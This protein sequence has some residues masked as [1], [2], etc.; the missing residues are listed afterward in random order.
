[1]FQRERLHGT[2]AAAERARATTGSEMRLRRTAI[3]KVIAG[4]VGAQIALPAAAL[5]IG[6]PSHVSRL[7]EPLHVEI[8]I[9]AEADDVDLR[10]RLMVD[11]QIGRPGAEA[12]EIAQEVA[13][14]ANGQ[15]VLRITSRAVVNEPI[16]TLH[17]DLSDRGV[18][19]RRDLTLLF[20]PPIVDVPSA[21]IVARAAAL[22]DAPTA[23]AAGAERN[24]EASVE[25]EA[26]DQPVTV[27]ALAVRRSR[28]AVARAPVSTPRP[29]SAARAVQPV[30]SP[31]PTQATAA[32]TSVPTMPSVSAPS[33]RSG[34]RHTL[35]VRHG[36]T[37]EQIAARVR[38]SAQTPV[39]TMAKLLRWQNPRAF[40]PRSGALQV[41]VRLHFPRGEAL[42][43]AL[44]DFAPSP[45]PATAGV[46]A[47]GVTL[48]PTATATAA[49]AAVTVAA[50]MLPAAATT[51]MLHF[52]EDLSGASLQTLATA[53]TSVANTAPTPSADA[54]AVAPI[55]ARREPASTEAAATAAAGL[56]VP[57]TLPTWLV[58]AVLS[59]GA[60]MAMLLARL[61]RNTPIPVP[62]PSQRAFQRGA[63][64]PAL[65]D[66]WAQRVAATVKPAAAA[67]PARDGVAPAARP[68]SGWDPEHFDLDRDDVFGRETGAS[69]PESDG[70]SQG[71]QTTRR[72]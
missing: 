39:A 66:E 71:N 65:V 38:P 46:P 68:A 9:Q 55:A 52:A 36:E 49:Q 54:V 14:D 69:A 35:P 60:G 13:S 59:L 23:T 72:R 43:A 40:E 25:A 33:A 21:P 58:A 67:R 41:G 4:M 5:G 8:P 31:A 20:D 45:V 24:A 47:S 37:L 51:P 56:S 27:A 53:A 15:R 57:T 19:L 7:F 63:P 12:P 2:E 70:G 62:P 26:P 64:P 44:A 18:Q 3:A 17:V 29:A 48:Q 42:L 34:W 6:E 30:E 22:P 32:P 61:L 28:T 10:V 16:L 1:M 11:G 50:A